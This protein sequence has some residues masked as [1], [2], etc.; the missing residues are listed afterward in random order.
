MCADRAISTLPTTA[1]CTVVVGS[2]RAIVASGAP[3]L[4]PPLQRREARCARS[5]GAGDRI[6]AIATANASHSLQGDPAFDDRMWA[7]L[8]AGDVQ[9]AG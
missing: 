7:H 4:S 9:S 1:L 6:A 3:T 8:V 5:G 2:V